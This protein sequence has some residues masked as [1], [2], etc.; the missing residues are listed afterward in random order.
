[1]HTTDSLVQTGTWAWGTEH[2][3]WELYQA[4]S[5]PKPADCT[6]AFCVAIVPGGKIVLEREER[7]WG[8]IGGHIDDGETIQQA[9]T[10]EC[11][12]EGGFT[13]EAP[14]LFGYRKIIAQQPV[15]HPTPGRVYPFPISYIAYYYAVSDTELIT[16]TEQETLEVATLTMQQIADLGLA[17][18]STI[19]LGWDTYRHHIAGQ[20]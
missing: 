3:D 15:A 14:V 6:A 5:L 2:V 7:G 9:L 11:L 10:R 4:S 8:M 17:D 1:M 12:E 13:V 16:P 19:Q 18:F 20:R